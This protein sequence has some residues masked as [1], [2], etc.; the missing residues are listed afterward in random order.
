MNLVV[1]GPQGSG[2]GTQAEL[3]SK[4]FNLEHIDMGG[5]LRQVAKMDTPLGKEIYHIQN[6][7]KT[8]VPSKILKEVLNLKFASLSREKGL[9]IDGAPRTLDQVE[10]V[11]SA[12]LE[13]GRKI[14]LVVFIE[15]PEKESIERISKRWSCQNCKKGF[16][17]GVDVKS[18]DDKCPNCGSGIMQ[19]IDDTEEGVKKR[20]EVFRKET[21]PVIDYFE[22]KGK[23][24]R[25]DGSQSI[26]KVF[27]DIKKYVKENL[28][29]D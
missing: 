20:L 23:L 28:N 15:I 5:T 25:I 7:T 14:N 13:F 22:K 17:M 3:L 4:E 18:Q 24:A 12:L 6:V 21:L 2:K 26:P 29:N 1:L 8:L 19:R 27:E 9:L 11:E 10:Y 16:I